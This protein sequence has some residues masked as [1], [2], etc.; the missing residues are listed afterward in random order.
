MIETDQQRRWWFATHPEFSS[1]RTGQRSKHLGEE[2]EDSG[3]PS[4]ESIDAYVDKRLEHEHDNVIIAMLKEMKRWGGT[5]GQNLESYAELGLEWPGKE[6]YEEGWNEGYWAIHDGKAPPD[7]APND[8]SPYARG[9]REGATAA[10][11]EREAWAQKWLDPLLILSGTH[12]SKILGRQLQ[13]KDDLRPSADHE[14]HHIVAWRHWRAIPAREVLEKY[15]IDINSVDNG[16]WLL[17]PYNRTLANSQRYYEA[18]NGM[19]S[20]ATSRKEAL[21]ILSNIK[22]LLSV[23]RFPL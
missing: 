19:L 21:R 18:V 23:G 20:E 12:P 22:Q 6:E 10:L 3:K 14:A 1:R 16:V 13:E 5:A 15:S 7:L 11:D 8:K 2:D 17:R 9:V 4:P